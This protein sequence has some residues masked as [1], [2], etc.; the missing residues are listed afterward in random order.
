MNR[1]QFNK[2][3][4]P[5]LFSMMVDSYRPRATDEEWR[6]LVNKIG[7]VKSNSVRSY[8]E[9]AYFAGLGVV[10]QKP[11]GSPISY[12]E[13]VQGPTKR[14]VH[15]TYGL[16]VRLTEELIDDTL[17][18]EVPTEM[19]QITSE[20]GAASRET[21]NALMFDLFNSGTATTSHT[22]GDS[23]AI[24]SAA[25]VA[26]RGGTWSNILSPTADP[27]ATALQEA[28][29]Q[30]ENTKDDT[31]KY[32]RIRPRWLLTNPKNE[33]KFKE[34]LQSGFDPESSNNAK[35]TLLSRGLQLITT[36]YYTDSDAF[37]LLAPP[38]KKDSGVI[39][40]MRRKV[41][42]AKDGDFDTGDAKFKVTFR[43]SIEIN[44]PNNMF[45]SG[46]A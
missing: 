16:G 26:L 5:G 6:S 4:V 45:L 7:T 29:R 10:A 18:S 23:L 33:W 25:H 42:F 35:N 34:L 21:L 40:F 38:P 3:V 2:A 36:P 14:W 44:K 32:Q 19:S 11:E 41:S 12:D 24:F 28:I 30:F 8:E 31:G 17:Y 46:G 20:L 39:A 13:M 43:H 15:K 1:A 9:S 37:I 27:S 22:A